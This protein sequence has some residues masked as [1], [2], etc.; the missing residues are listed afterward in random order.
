[1]QNT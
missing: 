1:V